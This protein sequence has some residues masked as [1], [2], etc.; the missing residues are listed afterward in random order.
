[1]VIGLGETPRGRNS[2]SETV[3]ELPRCG[4]TCST[5]AGSARKHTEFGRLLQLDNIMAG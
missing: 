2:W 4:A 3:E 1:V 5:L